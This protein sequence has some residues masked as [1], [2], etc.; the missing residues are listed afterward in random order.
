LFYREGTINAPIG[1]GGLEYEGV[2]VMRIGGISAEP[3]VLGSAAAVVFAYLLAQQLFSAHAERRRVA[4]LLVASVVVLF[5]TYSTSG[6][7]AALGATAVAVTLSLRYVQRTRIGVLLLIAAG[8][9]LLSS[10]GFVASMVNNRLTSRIFGE[11]A[12]LSLM[13]DMYVFDA[14]RDNPFDAIFGYG[15]GGADMAVLPYMEWLHLKYKRTPTPSVTAVRMLG[16][17]GVVGCALLGLIVASWSRR[18]VRMGESAGGAFILMGF[19]AAILCSTVALS[20]YFYTAGAMLALAALRS[21]E[22]A[23][24]PEQMPVRTPIPAGAPAELALTAN[25][26]RSVVRS[27]DTP[28]K[29]L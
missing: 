22:F 25:L 7:A 21:S 9:L 27:A 10:V 8:V 4:V 20:V 2:S 1:A 29:P 15:L 26:R 13:K 5:L 19:T 24:A 6:W 16:D 23:E 18:L 17:L 14:F 11:T 3:K 28:N 12:E